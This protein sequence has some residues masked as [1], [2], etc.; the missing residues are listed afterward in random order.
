MKMQAALLGEINERGQWRNMLQLWWAENPEADDLQ[1]QKTTLGSTSVCQD[2]EF[3]AT[4]VTGTPRLRRAVN[5]Q[6]DY[7]KL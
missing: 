4:V 5:L 2:Q 6:Y 1:Q 7:C 3:E